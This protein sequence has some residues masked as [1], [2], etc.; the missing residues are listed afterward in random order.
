M[1]GTKG[2]PLPK[3]PQTAQRKPKFKKKDENESIIDNSSFESLSILSDPKEHGFK[4]KRPMILKTPLNAKTR[5]QARYE[6][7]SNISSTGKL[8]SSNK[9]SRKIWDTIQSI[10]KQS[11]S[12]KMLK[13]L[14]LTD[15]A[16]TER[17]EYRMKKSP[18]FRNLK[19]MVSNYF[20]VKEWN[21]SSSSE[22]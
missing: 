16:D 4:A 2:Y 6:S 9:K 13:S 18:R 12:S 20:H 17:R 7:Q 3:R 11:Q 19:N 1:L 22:S 21:Q 15:G 10:N 5:A 8:N 14:E